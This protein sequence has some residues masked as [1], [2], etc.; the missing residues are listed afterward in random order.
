MKDLYN[1]HPVMHF[2]CRSVG[3]QRKH[4]ACHV[5]FIFCAHY[6]C[7]QCLE[8]YSNVHPAMHFRCRSV[9]TQRKHTTCHVSFIFGAHRMQAYYSSLSA[10]VMCILRCTSVVAPLVLNANTLRVMFLLYLS[11]IV[12]MHTVRCVL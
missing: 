9:D 1:V 12:C 7:I 10:I 5:S 3:T 8:C 6:A 4:T 2:R 11:Y